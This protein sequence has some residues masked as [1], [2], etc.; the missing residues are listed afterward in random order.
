MAT[1]FQKKLILAEAQLERNATKPTDVTNKAYVDNA[2][3]ENTE[4]FKNN[5]YAMIENPNK[6]ITR[7]NYQQH[8]GT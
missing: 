4:N 2:I 5:V 1:L 6:I 7:V 3:K 8:Y